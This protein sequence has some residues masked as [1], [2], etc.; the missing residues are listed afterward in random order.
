MATTAQGAPAPSAT[1]L[2]RLLVAINDLDCMAQTGMS[3][4]A[5][6]ARLALLAME[7]PEAY[8]GENLLADAL[9]T[10]VSIADNAM[11]DIN[12]RAEEFDCNYVD[13]TE[14]RRNDAFFKAREQQEPIHA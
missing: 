11:Y 8:R 1:D 4:V 9:S 10:I 13:R 2:R 14:R 3:R 5:S 12:A 6:I 7:A